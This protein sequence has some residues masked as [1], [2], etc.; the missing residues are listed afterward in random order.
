[1]VFNS[2]AFLV[3]AVVFLTVYFLLRGRHRLYWMLAGSYFFYGWWDVRFLG[4][5]ILSTVVDFHLGK[6]IR[7]AAD[8]TRRSRWLWLSVGVNLGILG[9]FKYAGF[10]TEGFRQLAALFGWIPPIPFLEV[11][12]PVGISFYTFQT[13]SYTIDIYRGRMEPTRD[14]WCFAT[15]VACWPQLVAGPIVR[16]ADFL[17]QLQR[18]LPA[19]TARI[20]SGLTRIGWGFFKKVAVA[21]SL[22]PFVDQVWSAP[23]HF[24]TLNL[25][26]AVLFYSFQLYCDFSGYSDIAIGFA[27]IMGYEFPE[28]FRTPYFSRHFSEFWTRWHIS[29]SSWLRD[30]LYIPLGGNRKGSWCTL[31]NLMLTMLLGGLWHGANWTFVVWGGIHGVLLVLQRL[32][33]GPFRLCKRYVPGPMWTGLAMLTV[34]LLTTLA[35]VFFRSPDLHTAVAILQDL[36]RLDG[37]APTG[38][39]NKFIVARGVGLIGS[40]LMVEAA[41]AYLPVGPWLSDRPFWRA[42]VVAAMLFAILLFGNFAADAF[43]YFQF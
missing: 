37:W 41:A 35:W 25:W 10:F 13:L 34:F 33:E 17:P 20:Q 36:F 27:R 2:L 43:I 24:T 32:L 28:N 14:I 5:I 7:A 38:L 16:A 29:L 1:M 3:F 15:F 8:P 30:Y 6:T 22:A 23:A 39:M 11:V 19:D 42:F 4:L 26:V 9:F 31:R 40:L 18:Y 21:D 12:L